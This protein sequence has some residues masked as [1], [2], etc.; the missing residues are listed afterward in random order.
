M[1]FIC[2][3]GFS[4]AAR[5]FYDV[6]ILIYLIPPI[7]PARRGPPSSVMLPD[8]DRGL[9]AQPGG[10]LLRVVGCRCVVERG[11]MW[12]L[13]VGF[14]V[15]GR[16]FALTGKSPRLRLLW[17]GMKEEKGGEEVYN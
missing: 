4:L 17:G 3:E 11:W 7:F 1:G 8:L 2:C 12:C 15:L 6:F 13:L 14:A 9:M 5:L 10:W 16:A